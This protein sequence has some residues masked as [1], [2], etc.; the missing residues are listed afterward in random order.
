MDKPKKKK[1]KVSPT[2]R[3]KKLLA[4]AGL[5]V[6]VVEHWNSFCRIR[7]DLF[8]FIDLIALDAEGGRT[9]GVQTTVGGSLAAR[10]T[11]ATSDAVRPYVV[12]WIMAGNCLEFHGWRKLGNRWKCRVVTARLDCGA[13]IFEEND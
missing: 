3:S 8:G 11:K 7:Q 10:L 2:Q 1:S 6:A 5:R 9:I 12:A 4:D 13:I